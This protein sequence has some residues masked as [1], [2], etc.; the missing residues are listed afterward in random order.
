LPTEL[1]KWLLVE[2][3][4]V[5]GSTEQVEVH[6]VRKL[7]N[8][9]KKGH[10]ELQDWAKII[11]IQQSAIG[12]IEELT[13]SRTSNSTGATLGRTQSPTANHKASLCS[14]RRRQECIEV[15]PQPIQKAYAAQRR[16][17]AD[18]LRFARAI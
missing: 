14:R 10:K 8:L 7:V 12:I 13:H 15:P 3:Y 11:A 9:K 17:A 4:E 2:E 1:I 16:V 5:C 18:A 6:R